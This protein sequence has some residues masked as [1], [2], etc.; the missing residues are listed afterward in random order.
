MLACEL[1]FFSFVEANGLFVFNEVA[2]YIVEKAMT[3][4]VWYKIAYCTIIVRVGYLS[5]LSKLFKMVCIHVNR[6]SSKYA[7]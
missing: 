6:N 1:T 3:C 2:P 7:L 4:N 5:W